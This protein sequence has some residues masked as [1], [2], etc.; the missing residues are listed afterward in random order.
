M[1]CLTYSL[2][3]PLHIIL[4][5]EAFSTGRR[6]QLLVRMKTCRFNLGKGNLGKGRNKFGRED[7]RGDLCHDSPVDGI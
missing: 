5:L 7:L 6:I 4:A 1:P 3:S 2:D